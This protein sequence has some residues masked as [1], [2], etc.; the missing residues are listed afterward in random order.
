[1]LCAGMCVVKWHFR[2]STLT[3][4]YRP[5]QC[6]GDSIATHLST[7]F[8]LL[9]FAELIVQ[10]FQIFFSPFYSQVINLF[11]KLQ[12]LFIILSILP[13]YPESCLS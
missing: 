1:M 2:P 6:D 12:V 5:L 10:V 13:Y 9:V 4:L 11:M 8:I 7:C 3:A